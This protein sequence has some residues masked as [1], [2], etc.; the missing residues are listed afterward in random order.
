M[1]KISIIMASYNYANYISEAI[2]SVINQTYKDW[3]LIV[4][5]DGSSDNSVEIIEQFVKKD[6]RIK[7][8]INEKNLGLAKTLQKGIE[9]SSAEWIAF[10]ESD[11][12]FTPNSLEEK[13][14]AI[15]SGADLIFTD[16]EMIGDKDKIKNFQKYFEDIK[17]N[18]IRLD[19]SAFIENFPA[20]I[21]KANIISGFSSVMTKKELL[22]KCKFNPLCKASLDHYLWA[23]L[24]SFAKIY[25][26]N[27][28]LSYWRIHNNSY[29]NTYN[30]SWIIGYL[31]YIS[32]F[33]ET[34]KNKPFFVKW[35]LTLNY[36]RTRL[37]YLKLNKETI[38]LNLLNNKFIF[39]KK[40]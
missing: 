23:Q 40:L 15:I 5:D 38:K 33:Q 16:F 19:K 32:L 35:I 25:Y 29:I 37:I 18:F 28:K 30:H 1:T 20:I 39:E 24:S 36:A 12:I 14:N 31:F 13:V 7:L 34:I 22:K 9:L 27:K 4:I 8:F 21:A 26:I 10:L 11:D 3:E 2:E 17:S 6:N